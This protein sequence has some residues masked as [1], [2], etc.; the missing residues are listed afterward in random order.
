MTNWTKFLVGIALFTLAAANLPAQSI[1]ATLTGVVSDPS[2]AVVPNATVKLKSEATGSTRDTVTNTDGYYSFPSV[3]VGDF[4]YE[5]SVE[6]QGFSSY[7]A[8]GI[9]LG[10]GEKRNMNV[11]LKVGATAETVE[12]SGTAEA[13]TTVDSGEKSATL[14]TKELQNFVQVGSNAAEFIKI[15]PG[16]GINNGTSNK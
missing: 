3:P 11:V 6:A 15:M 13:L 7:K 16:F 8:S 14:T 5:L 12:V 10:G 4:T 1:F 9:A 2:G